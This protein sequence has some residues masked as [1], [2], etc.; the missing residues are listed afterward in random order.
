M[1]DFDF[2]TFTSASCV[3]G[4]VMSMGEN[5]DYSK[6]KAICIGQQTA[7]EA[8]KYNMEIHISNVATIDSIVECIEEINNVK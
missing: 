6:V 3:K 4:F 8:S 7:T 5:K 2:V 1:S